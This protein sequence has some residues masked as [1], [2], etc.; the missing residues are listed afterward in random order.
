MRAANGHQCHI[1]VPF[2]RAAAGDSEVSVRLDLTTATRL[3]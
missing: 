1:H 2:R 3:T